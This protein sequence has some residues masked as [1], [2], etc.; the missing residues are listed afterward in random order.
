MYVQI[1]AKHLSLRTPRHAVAFVQRGVP[2]VP[3]LIGESVN[4]WE[5][6]NGSAQHQTATEL[7]AA[8]ITEPGS[9]G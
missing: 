8:A 4:V 1:C 3:I 2:E 9:A 5:T 7:T 6:A